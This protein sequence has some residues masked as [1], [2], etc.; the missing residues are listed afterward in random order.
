MSS[1]IEPPANAAELHTAAL[2]MS[3]ELATT[4]DAFARLAE[5]VE[6]EDELPELF[7]SPEARAVDAAQEKIVASCL[8]RQTEFDATAEREAF[9]DTP[10]IPP[11]MQEVVLV[12]F[13]CVQGSAED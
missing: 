4:G 8:D 11:E 2:G 7:S 1:A 13:G 12:A 10:W 3:A 6:T 9:A 5:D